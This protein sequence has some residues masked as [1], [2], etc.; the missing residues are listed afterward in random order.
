M[1]LLWDPLGHLGV[2]LVPLWDALGRPWAPLGSL[3][4]PLGHLGVPF[5]KI[6]EIDFQ[7]GARVEFLIEARSGIIGQEFI[8]KFPG[9]RGCGG[10]NYRLGP[11][12]YAH[13]GSG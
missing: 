2:A 9:F 12:F 1:G 8:R 11:S 7:R 13:L 5:W 6:L 3:W 4:L 10:I